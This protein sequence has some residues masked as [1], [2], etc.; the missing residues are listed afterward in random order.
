MINRHTAIEIFLKGIENV[1]PA[2]LISQSFSADGNLLKIKNITIDLSPINNIFV[3]G[4]GKASAAMATSIERILGSTISDGHIVTKYGHSVPLVRIGITEASHPVPDQAGVAGTSILSSIADSA[5]ENDLVICL[6]SGGGSALLTDLPDECSLDD[7]ILLNIC[8]LGVGADIRELNAVR[9][10]LSRVKGGWLAK[11]AFPARVVSLILSDVTGDPVDVIA[12]GPTVADTTTYNDAMSVLKRYNV[13]SR[14]PSCLVDILKAGLS[15]KRPET[16]KADDPVFHN[17][18]NIIIGNNKTAL[19]TAARTAESMGY[20]CTIITDQLNGDVTEVSSEIFKTVMEIKNRPLKRKICLLYGGE[21]TVRV[22]GNK[23]HGGRNQ[24]LALLL[25]KLLG[26]TEGV[27]FLAAGT[28]GT[29]GPTDAAGA[30]ADNM[31]T[32]NAKLLK[33]DI[34]DYIKRF[35][36]YNFFKQ[37][38]GL[39]KTGP[40]LTNVMD[41]IV[42]LI[43]N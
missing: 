33:I 21:T 12:S 23:G 35:D 34:D 24:H 32:K 22:S 18:S 38:G 43:D 27:T 41:I 29:D 19:D 36:S 40:T 14:I 37:E 26:K 13:E 39:I 2:H 3:I 4:F 17:T 7:I 20:D 15:G 42:V 9:K 16:P 31:T 1:N 28:D 10:H 30:V 25:A 6:V 8:L 5:G 11:R